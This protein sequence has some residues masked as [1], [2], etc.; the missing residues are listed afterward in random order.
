MKG[1]LNNKEATDEVFDKDGYFHTGDIASVDNDG[2]YIN[3]KKYIYI[4]L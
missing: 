3:K 4:F 1:Y 2:D